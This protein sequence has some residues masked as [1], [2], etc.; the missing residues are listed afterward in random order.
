MVRVKDKKPVNKGLGQKKPEHSASPL[1][2]PSPPSSS[3]EEDESVSS[4]DQ[5]SV[6]SSSSTKDTVFM[7]AAAKK[8]PRAPPASH[9]RKHGQ[10]K[11][12]EGSSRTKKGAKPAEDAEKVVKKHR[13][14]NGTVALR[15]IRKYQRSCDLLIPK[16]AMQRLAREVLQ[17]VEPHG[18]STDGI[19]RMTETA[20]ESLREAAES[21]LIGRMEDSLLCALHA[22]RITIQ[23]RDMHLARRLSSGQ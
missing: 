9:I 10:T 11:R 20:L 14:R 23:P 2:P 4:A 16:A 5:S 7:A 22:K 12:S 3:S 1:P 13:W 8:A 17:E 18:N 15:E 6:S 21:F 19:T